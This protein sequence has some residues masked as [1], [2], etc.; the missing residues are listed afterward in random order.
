MTKPVIPQPVREGEDGWDLQ[1]RNVEERIEAAI[2]RPTLGEGATL[3]ES[4]H[5]DADVEKHMLPA[6]HGYYGLDTHTYTFSVAA[7]RQ[8]W[9]WHFRNEER[10]RQER[11]AEHER[12]TQEFNRKIN[13]RKAKIERAKPAIEVV[14]EPKMRRDD[15]GVQVR[16]TI[17]T[18][19]GPL[20]YYY[21]AYRPV[22][23]RGQPDHTWSKWGTDFKAHNMPKA[24]LVCMLRPGTAYDIAVYGGS[25]HGGV[26]SS[27][28]TVSYTEP[29]A[30]QQQ[31][32][33]EP[34][35][36]PALGAITRPEDKPAPTIDAK[37][38]PS[39]EHR[40]SGTWG[41]AWGRFPGIAPGRNYGTIVDAAFTLPDGSPGE[42][43]AL[44]LTDS[45]TLRVTLAHG[46][47]SDQFPDS[48]GVDTDEYANVFDT[49]GEMQSFGLGVA[50]DYKLASGGAGRIMVSKTS[51]FQLL[52]T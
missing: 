36:A 42:V 43:T 33:I 45:V 22:S 44:F 21:F 26:Y 31:Q 48:V 47:S 51:A 18:G 3:V 19:P 1:Q 15:F 10:I 37:P 30:Q 50:R 14:G 12:K 29:V 28:V 46:T 20:E 34:E 6:S 40:L 52:W 13:E 5:D 8:F 4:F 23:M 24:E 17:G 27:P 49:P 11:L 38:L 7:Q 25:R 41:N 2:Y 9:E 39:H 35:P 32:Q 16:A